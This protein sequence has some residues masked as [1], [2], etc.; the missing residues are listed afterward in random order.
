[1]AMGTVHLVGAGPGHPG[2]LTVRG[3]ELIREA[4]AI[5]YDRLASP[6]LL[7]EA[8]PDV[9]LYFVGKKA[10]HHTVPQQEIERQLIL[11]A[12]R[13]LR[14][15]RL[16][17]GD[18][19]V[20]GRG[21]EEAIQLQ[22]AG[23][24][25]EIVPGITS[26]VAVPA[27]AGI[28]VTYRDVSPSFTVVTGHRKQDAQA[29]DWSLHAKQSGT[30]VILMGVKQLHEIVQGL[31]EGGKAETTPV[32]MIRWGTR[33]KQETL[34]GTLSDIVVLA[35]E[36]AFQA[37]AVIVV[38]D[39]AG[40]GNDLDWYERLPLMGKRLFLLAPSKTELRKVS[41]RL[42]ALG[43]ETFGLAR[44]H[45]APASDAESAMMMSVVTEL[46]DCIATSDG[47]RCGVCFRSTHAVD[48]FFQTLR[49]RRVDVRFLSQ[50]K[51]AAM[52][53]AV[54]HQL[55]EYGFYADSVSPKL[56][57]PDMASVWWFESD[58]HHTAD[59][60]PDVLL[61]AKGQTVHHFQMRRLSKGE[62]QW[63]QVANDWLAD[64]VDEICMI[65]DCHDDPML[66]SML[67]LFAT[68]TVA[69]TKRTTVTPDS[70]DSDLLR[71]LSGCVD[72]ASESTEFAR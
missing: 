7:T 60:M 21:A 61:H 41:S 34:R 17:G 2:L 15:V 62:S 11:L 48:S 67:G 44:S 70:S 63:I 9:E 43:A 51:F 1:M 40:F 68:E 13:G 59:E 12:N 5:V 26:A 49:E 58:I 30:L 47:L 23:I 42:E 3:L 19:F 31:V 36:R 10:D 52:N 38:G 35:R 39:V 18:P 27:Y 55:A 32:A 53:D 69:H 57:A 65:S 29:I 16:K 6:R 54:A 20:F 8:K 56:P 33:G 71:L 50:V 64:G 22:E 28:P 14:V 24:P 46:V 66:D 25:F 45:L 4:D 37:P 72:N